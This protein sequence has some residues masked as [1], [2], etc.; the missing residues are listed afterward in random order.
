MKATFFNKFK[1]ALP[2]LVCSPFSWSTTSRV[3]SR[4]M[5]GDQKCIESLH[6][7]PDFGCRPMILTVDPP[8]SCSTQD[9]YEQ[10]ALGITPLKAN[11]ESENTPLEKE[12]HLYTNHQF[13]GSMFVLGGVGFVT[14][15]FIP[16]LC[17]RAKLATGLRIWDGGIVLAKC[18]AKR[19]VA[20]HGGL[21]SYG[22]TRGTWSTTRRKW[23]NVFRGLLRLAKHAKT[24]PDPSDFFSEKLGNSE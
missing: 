12:N 21:E 20:T 15:D 18:P 11:M 16:T 10:S 1:S 13:L 7:L 22:P 4:S 19:N 6:S 8:D 5:G 14:C 3:T 24:K 2:T 23:H 9:I 17:L